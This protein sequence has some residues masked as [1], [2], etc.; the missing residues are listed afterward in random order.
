THPPAG[1][2][3][4]RI[5]Q[6]NEDGS[7]ILSSIVSVFVDAREWTEL[8]VFPNPATDLLTLIPQNHSFLM[9][10]T[11]IELFSLQGKS[12]MMDFI[13][14]ASTYHQIKV[15]HLPKGVYILRIHGQDQRL[16]QKIS[17][18]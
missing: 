2:T 8:Q 12:V 17:I 3:Y 15:D 7:T 13:K 10:E 11:S 9:E 5:Q 14:E 16:Q 4:Y 1:H 6:E 18:Q